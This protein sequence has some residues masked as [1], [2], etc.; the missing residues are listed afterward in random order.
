MQIGVIATQL[1]QISCGPSSPRAAVRQGLISE[2]IVTRSSYITLHALPPPP[3]AHANFELFSP[4]ADAILSL[5]DYGR[6]KDQT[7]GIGSVLRRASCAARF[8]VPPTW[9]RFPESAIF[10]REFVR[11]R[12]WTRHRCSAWLLGEGKNSACVDFSFIDQLHPPT[13]LAERSSREWST[14]HGNFG[15]SAR[16]IPKDVPKWRWSLLNQ[17]T[18]NPSALLNITDKQNKHVLRERGGQFLNF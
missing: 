1:G 9:T 11:V 7:V 3:R 5:A 17:W 10:N 8:F 4:R 6:K 18:L 2:T 14:F 13:P 15:I 16:V 12:Y